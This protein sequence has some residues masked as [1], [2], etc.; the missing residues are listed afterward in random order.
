VLC[1][2]LILVLL[3][4]SFSGG[5]MAADHRPEV[6]VDVRQDDR[7]LPTVDHTV[8]LARREFAL[9]LTLDGPA[10]FLVSVSFTSAAYDAALAGQ[11]LAEIP[12]M[13]APPVEE[14]IFNPYRSTIVDD[15]AP[16]RWYYADEIDYVFD[17]IDEENGRLVC[18]RTVSTVRT[19]DDLDLFV[20]I[21]ELTRPELYLVFVR[22]NRPADGQVRE[23]ARGCLRLVFQ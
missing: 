14:E 1:R 7:L 10:E 22:V 4:V 20:P 6:R 8:T 16:H 21:E 2:G 13:N 9:V 15:T 12:G 18:T 3:A 23:T 11:P 5:L 19:P 17:G